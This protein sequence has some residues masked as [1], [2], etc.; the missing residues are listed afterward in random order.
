MPALI[1]TE[2]L[3][4]KVSC[5]IITICPAPIVGDHYLKKILV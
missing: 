2:Q 4:F 1:L 3:K 5:T